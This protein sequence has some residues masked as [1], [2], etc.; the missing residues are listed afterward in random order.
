MSKSPSKAYHLSRLTISPSRAHEQINIEAMNANVNLNYSVIT[1]TA[2]IR[3]PCNSGHYCFNE[4]YPKGT[5]VPIQG[6]LKV[7]RINDCNIITHF[8]CHINIIC[9]LSDKSAFEEVTSNIPLSNWKQT[10]EKVNQN[11]FMHECHSHLQKN[12]HAILCFV[13]RPL[14]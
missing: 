8:R 7:L 2:L 3:V 5:A 10:L 9:V 12:Q 6:K 14:V 4:N 11:D 1:E 13:S